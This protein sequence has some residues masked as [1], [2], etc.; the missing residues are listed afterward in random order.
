M[1]LTSHPHPALRLKKEY[2][3]TSHPPQGPHGLFHDEI[4]FTSNPVLVPLLEATLKLPFH[5]AI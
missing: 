3:H 4:Y 5:E 2:S 1:A